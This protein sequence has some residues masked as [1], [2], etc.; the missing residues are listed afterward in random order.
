MTNNQTSSLSQQGVMGGAR[1]HY[2]LRIKIFSAI[3]L[4]HT[5]SKPKAMS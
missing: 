5:G 2:V 1:P 4:M 3:P